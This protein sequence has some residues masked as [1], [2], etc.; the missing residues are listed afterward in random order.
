[1]TK[2]IAVGKCIHGRVIFTKIQRE[3]LITHADTKNLR[4]AE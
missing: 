3:G 2:I 1:M 4:T